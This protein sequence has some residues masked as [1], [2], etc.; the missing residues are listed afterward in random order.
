MSNNDSL[1]SRQ[2]SLVEV[3]KNLRDTVIQG[4]VG[5][6]R[7]WQLVH[8]IAH[9]YANG[10]AGLGLVR[11]AHHIC[12][13]LLDDGN[14]LDGHVLDLLDL[15]RRQR[16]LEQHLEHGHLLLVLEALAHPFLL[17]VIEVAGQ[18]NEVVERLLDHRLVLL[19]VVALDYSLIPFEVVDAPGVVLQCVLKA[20]LYDRT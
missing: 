11:P 6:A 8:L 18:A 2:I 14:H 12:Q 20:R 1:L 5:I 17:L 19:G 15:G 4:L 10:V 13:T 9:D 16:V 7:L 3:V